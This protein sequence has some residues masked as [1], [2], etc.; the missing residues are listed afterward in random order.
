[1][2][3]LLQFG[4]IADDGWNNTKPKM[5]TIPSRYPSHERVSINNQL[6]H[7]KPDINPQFD[8]LGSFLIG[9]LMDVKGSGRRWIKNTN[10]F[11][12]LFDQWQYLLSTESRS[13]SQTPPCNSRIG[14]INNCNA[15]GET[16]IDTNILNFVTIDEIENLITSN[17]KNDNI[18]TDTGEKDT[19]LMM[20]NKSGYFINCCEGLKRGGWV[21]MVG[22][23]GLVVGISITVIILHPILRF[24]RYYFASKL[25]L[26]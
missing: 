15:N 14:I 9:F 3:R 8:E 16:F 13:N 18:Y 1:M 12:W 22:I 20:M 11:R 7:N 25:G 21:M 6:Y 2:M 24:L 5:I 4:V 23:Y 10:T 26:I 17:V 19:S